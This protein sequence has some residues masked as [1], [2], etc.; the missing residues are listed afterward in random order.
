MSAILDLLKQTSAY[1]G[2]S[3]AFIEALYED[4]LQDP[5]SIEPGWR[6]QFDLLAKEAANEPADTPHSKI[7]KRFVELAETPP[8]LRVECADPA[9]AEKQAAVLRLI[10]AY[11]VRGHQNA[12]LDPLQLRNKTPLD[13]LSASFHHLSESDMQKTFHTGSLYAPREMKLRDI[14]D[15]VKEIYTS[16]TGFEYMH[17]TATEEKR[18][19]QRRIEGYRA[20]PAI[21]N[22]KRVWLLKMLT[23]AE[24]LERSFDVAPVTLTEPIPEDGVDLDGLVQRHAL[25]DFR[26]HRGRGDRRSAAEG[27]KLDVRDAIRIDFEV[28]R[29][30]VAADR[31]ADLAD[32]VG[33]VDHTD[34]P[35]IAKM[36]HHCLAVEH[37]KFLRLKCNECLSDQIS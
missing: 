30:H 19:L 27:L 29:H 25:N 20:K 10:N 32:A 22:K 13:E 6:R 3:A 36:I 11:R 21:N 2:G 35:G 5:S 16:H 37:V 12:D 31:V 9:A 26:Q 8:S 14:I 33:I 4:Y 18:W 28:D 1:S 34:I 7:R 23:A 15:F 17:I 24:G